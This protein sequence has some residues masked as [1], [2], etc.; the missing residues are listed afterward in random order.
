MGKTAVISKFARLRTLLKSW[1]ARALPPRSAYVVAVVAGLFPFSAHADRE[2]QA[3]I[4]QLQTQVQDLQVR[5]ARIEAVLQGQGLLTLYNDIQTLK[6]QVAKLNGMGEVQ[7][8]QLDQLDRRQ[9]DLY[10]SLDQRITAQALA[11][12]KLKT[13]VG[14]AEP[15][16]PGAPVAPP[17]PAAAPPTAGAGPV[18][19]QA[20]GETQTYEAALARFK[21][22]E[23]RG[24]AE[25]FKA[26]QKKFPSSS[27]AANAQFWVGYSLYSLKDYKAA[28]A[29]MRSLLG[30][31]RQTPKAPDALLTIASC[32]VE[33]NQMAAAKAT[34]KELVRQ[35]PHSSAAAIGRKRLD[36]LK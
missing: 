1:P 31:H 7:G 30:N 22:G 13:Q 5:L 27:L 17:A 18:P 32:Q 34:L 14:G 9:L 12:E 15:T 3:Q 20:T 26:F 6:D 29:A 10:Q 23:Y 28:I 2:T 19:A 8:H 16:P 4:Q 35:Y 33:L 24:A 36:L 25:D 11:L 21:K